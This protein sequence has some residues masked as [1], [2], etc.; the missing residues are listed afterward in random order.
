MC[1]SIST[2]ALRPFQRRFIREAL[3][4]GVTIAAK[5][6]PRGNGKSTLCGWLAARIMT[7]NDPLF[8]AGTESVLVSGSIEQ[9]RIVFRV[10]RGF[11]GESEYRYLDSNTRIGMTHKETN[12]KLRIIGSNGKTAMGLLGCPWVIADEPG[13]WEINGGLLVWDALTTARGKPGSPLKI[14]IVGTLA[15]LATGPGHWW[16]DLVHSESDEST[17]VMK[18]QGDAKTWDQW[19]TIRKANPLTNISPEFRKQLLKERDEARHDSR[20]KARFLSYRLNI[21]TADESSMP[22]TVDDWERIEGR[23]V[24]PREGKP[25]VGADLGAGRAWSAACA[26]YSNGRVESLAI[27][28]GIPT[29]E[30]QEKRD[31]VPAGTYG[32]LVDAGTLRI[33]EGLGVQPPAML[34]DAV[35]ET[36]GRPSVLVCDRFRLPELQDAIGR[37]RGVRLEPR[38]A[39]W[40]DA[41]FDIRALRKVAMD[42]PMS[43]EKTSRRLLATSLAK[44]MVQNDD[45]GNTRLVKMG[46]NNEGLDD[47]AAALVLAAGAHAR[48]PKRPS[49]V[50]LGLV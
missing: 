28:P 50:Y 46:T 3:R 16:F 23:K 49:A 14:L 39:R 35:I 12:T 44:A 18:M 5:S 7:A 32:K 20:L 2:L 11:L 6:V 24:P 47:V 22:L 26:L 34:W 4:P 43:V 1:K 19:P 36:W 45:Q 27:A 29:I 37:G 10:A 33:A 31:R 38:V 25:I 48:R 21:P 41:A 30:A 42:G 8:R 15:P 13:S 9:A 17:F 40:S